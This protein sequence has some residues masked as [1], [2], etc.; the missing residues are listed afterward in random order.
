MSPAEAA[1]L[2]RH[3]DIAIVFG[4]RVEGEGFD[5]PDLSLSWGQDALIKA[6]ADA[7]PN[8]IVV[9][10]T[11]NPVTMPWQDKVRA[12]VEAWYSG[13]AGGPAI[14]EILTGSVNPSGR[15]PV[16]C[17]NPFMQLVGTHAG[18]RRAGRVGARCLAGLGSRPSNW[19]WDP[20]V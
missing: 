3:A 12:I 10:E 1:L 17:G 20:G 7:N 11:G 13:Q 16:G 15:L 14:A 9:L 8:T 18:D 6:V 5:S 19:E 2:A 4:I